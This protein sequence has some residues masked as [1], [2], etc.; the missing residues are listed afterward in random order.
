MK[1][2]LALTVA[3]VF[4]AV[5]LTSATA[6]AADG[7]KK[8]LSAA[9]AVAWVEKML[10]AGKIDQ[11]TADKKLAFI[12]SGG[13]MAKAKKKLSPADAVAW[14]EKMLAAGKI[15]QATADKK[16]ALIKSGK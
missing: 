11:A 12:K 5:G 4:A 10:A 14:V 2:T 16:L 1:R 8:K 7:D 13:L 9:D 6:V 15:D 3:I